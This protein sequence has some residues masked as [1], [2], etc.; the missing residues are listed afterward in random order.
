MIRPKRPEDQSAHDEGR[1]EERSQNNLCL[2]KDGIESLDTEFGIEIG[3]ETEDGGGDFGESKVEEGVEVTAAWEHASPSRRSRKNMMQHKLNPIP[4]NDRIIHILHLIHKEQHHQPLRPGPVRK[5]PFLKPP[6]GHIVRRPVRQSVL[7]DLLARMS[8]GNGHVRAAEEGD[9]VD[10]Q[11]SREYG[12]IAFALQYRIDVGECGNG[13]AREV[14]EEEE[15]GDVEGYGEECGCEGWAVEA[16]DVGVAFGLGGAF[17]GVVLV[18]EVVEDE[19][20]VGEE[21][22]GG[23]A[24]EARGGGVVWYAHGDGGCCVGLQLLWCTE[25]RSM[26]RTLLSK[27]VAVRT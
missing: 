9:E 15:A 23:A 8:I 6:L 22:G 1:H 3:K 17:G 12:A 2:G 7:D 27:N 10:R 4:P 11:V 26:L 21:E 25:T 14:F 24:F 5:H 13:D 20:F 19:G 16:V 18:G